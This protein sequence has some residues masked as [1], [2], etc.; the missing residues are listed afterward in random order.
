[1]RGCVWTGKTAL[2]SKEELINANSN[3]AVS[4]DSTLCVC[5]CVFMRVCV[6]VCSSCGMCVCVLCECVCVCSARQRYREHLTTMTRARAHTHLQVVSSLVWTLSLTSLFARGADC[7]CKTLDGHACFCN[8]R[9]CTGQ[10]QLIQSRQYIRESL[11]KPN[12]TYRKP[13]LIV[14]RIQTLHEKV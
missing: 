2:E 6:C 4:H 8:F 11:E 5:V 7:F 9:Y 3:I 1:M 13:C 12:N 14:Q 10:Y